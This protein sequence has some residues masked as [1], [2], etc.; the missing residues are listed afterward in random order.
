MGRINR[1]QRLQ[2]APSSHYVDTRTAYDLLGRVVKRWGSAVNPVQ[3]EYHA[4][5]GHLEKQH[6]YRG[7][8]G[9]EGS[10]WPATTGTADTTTWD[11]DAYTGLLKTKLDADSKGASYSYND[12]GQVSQRTWARGV[13]TT[14][15]YDANTAE[16]A[17]TT[18]SDSTPSLSFTYDRLG[19]VRN[20]SDVTGARAFGYSTTNFQLE[21][22]DLNDTFYG[23]NRDLSPIYDNLFRYAG[24]SWQNQGGSATEY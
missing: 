24:F 4:T 23:A 11:V 12:L 15:G 21:S 14:Y 19:L 8:N 16:L 13:T 18:Y 1:L 9:W 7:G 10:T 6:T 20:I 2:D 5:Y 3:Y 17:S 22:E